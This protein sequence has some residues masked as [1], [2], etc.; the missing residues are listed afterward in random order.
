MDIKSASSFMDTVDELDLV[1][2]AIKEA[3]KSLV[4]LSFYDESDVLEE[5]NK[6]GF[7]S[8]PSIHQLL[9]SNAGLEIAGSTITGKLTVGNTN[10]AS[11]I[12]SAL[13]AD[14]YTSRPTFKLVKP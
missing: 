5:L 9:D 7:S 3:A 1:S 10:L 11:K 6:L 4:W 8:F 12:L 14:T 13:R 2:H